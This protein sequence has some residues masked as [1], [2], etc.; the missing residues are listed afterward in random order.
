MQR[1]TIRE[2]LKRQP[3]QPFR[4][5]LADG[6]TFDIRHPRTNVLA[7][8]FVKIGIPVPESTNPLLCDHAEYVPLAPS[9]RSGA[10]PTRTTSR[11]KRQ[12]DCAGLQRARVGRAG[13]HPARSGAAW[14]GP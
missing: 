5:H 4:V 13:S 3:F 8:T 12:P 10:S 2:W 1:D 9:G 11:G 7:Q 6:R 14:L